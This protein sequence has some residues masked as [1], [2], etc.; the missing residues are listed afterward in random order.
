MLVTIITFFIVL[1]VLVLVHEF[2]HF[3]FF[4]KAGIKV[5][6][7]GFGYPPRLWSKKICETIYSINW[8]PFGGFVRLYGEEL[9]ET[10][11]IKKRESER[12]FFNKSKKIRTL[13]IISGVLANFILAVI[14]FSSVYSFSGIP[15][16]TNQ[17]KVIG[18]LPES[19]AAKSGLKAEDIILAVDEQNLES[20]NEKTKL[21]S[22]IGLIE[23][24]KGKE[25]SLTVERQKDNPCHEKVFGGGF[26]SEASPTTGEAVH[27]FSCQEGKLI[28][29]ATPRENP[30]EGEGPL[31]VVVFDVEMK[32]FPFWQMPWR[33][34]IEGLKE[35]FGWMVL[36]VGALKKMIIDLFINGNVPK[37]VAGPVG[38]FQITVVVAKSGFLNILQFI[39]VLSV[40]LAVVNILPFPALDGGRLVFVI[41]ELVTRRKPKV[42]VE[43]WVNTVGMAFLMLLIILITFNDI[44][45][46]LAGSELLKG[47]RKIWP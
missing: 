23:E 46:L 31:G 43:R 30:P 15:V 29:W 28:L 12:A 1:S 36:I 7:F 9:Q 6:E 8:L 21:N 44:K 24:K 26:I 35:A 42:S 4:K 16:K 3:F 33:G 11:K 19:P 25:V 37:D 17:V 5:E 18:V 32:K 39:G 45:R 41:Y 22:F 40:N 27:P 10:K 14:V 20:L 34:T 38:I 13:V 2:G 47:I